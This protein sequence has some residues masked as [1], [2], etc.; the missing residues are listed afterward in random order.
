MQMSQIVTLSS[1]LLIFD[2]LTPKETFLHLVY[3]DNDSYEI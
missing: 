2:Q 3:T 1:Y